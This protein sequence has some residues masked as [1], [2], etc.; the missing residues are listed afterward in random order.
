MKQE[1]KKVKRNVRLALLVAG[2]LAASGGAS[3]Q[4]YFSFEDIP[5]LED[6]EPTVAIDLDPEMMNFFGAATKGSQQGAASALEGITNIRVRVYEG[7][8]DGV[9][10]DLL[11]FVDDTSR[12]LER[13]GWRSVV[14]VNEDGER[15]R[16][17]MKLAEGG[18]NAGS[19]EGLTVMVLDTGG[20]N[21]A[22]FINLAG[23]IRP[24]QLGRVAAEMGMDD[25]FSMV[26]GVPSEPDKGPNDD[27]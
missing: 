13:D 22:V 25:M 5:G 8:A 27:L 15:V 23:L 24:E 12:T 3:A 21:E 7:I 10:A 4:G 19:I 18:A 1:A 9:E 14:R 2:L 16:I 17:F 11:K 20:G 6:A 26:P